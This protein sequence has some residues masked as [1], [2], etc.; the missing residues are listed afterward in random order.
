MKSPYEDLLHLPRPVSHKHPPMAMHER[1]AQFSPFAALTGYDAAIAESRRLTD[2]W[3]ELS[4][5]EQQVLDETQRRIQSLLPQRPTVTITYF[6]P[7]ERKEGG[8]YETDTKPLRRID[9]VSRL[10]HLTD[11]QTIESDRIV[12]LHVPQRDKVT[13]L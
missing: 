2:R 13:P 5:D 12:E 9:P 11:G 3:V 7:D 6:V 10:W 4:E 8:H 1:A